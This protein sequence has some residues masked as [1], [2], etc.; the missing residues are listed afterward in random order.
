MNRLLFQIRIAMALLLL[1][2]GLV[3]GFSV[4]VADT[5]SC[6]Q[7]VGAHQATEMGPALLCDAVC[8]EHSCLPDTAGCCTGM[9]GGSCGFAALVAPSTPLPIVENNGAE[10]LAERASSFLGLGPQA[11][12]RPPRLVA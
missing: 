10:W 9:V 1:G 2:L 3:F 8:D 7:P 11:R 4:A 6:A 12:R 5:P